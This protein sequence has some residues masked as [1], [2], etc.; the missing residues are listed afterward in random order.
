MSQICSVN[1]RRY[2]AASTRWAPIFGAIMGV[3]IG[4]AT[5]LLGIVLGLFMP[6]L[7]AILIPVAWIAAIGAF[8]LA[9]SADCPTCASSLTFF[10]NVE[11]SG[12]KHS[13]RVVQGRLVDFSAPV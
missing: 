13:L 6:F 9:R 11:C 2:R 8:I 7:F 12:C 10:A 3:V 1:G 4:I 5:F